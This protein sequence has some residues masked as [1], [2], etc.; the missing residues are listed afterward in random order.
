MKGKAVSSQVQLILAAQQPFV[1][2]LL[3]SG[4]LHLAEDPQ[5][6]DFLAGNPQEIA[7]RR[8][9]GTLKRWIEPKDK[10]WF[11]YKMMHPAAQ[12]AAAAGLS[13]ELGMQFQPEDIL[14]ARGAHGALWQSLKIVLEAEDEVIY[15]SPPWFFYEAIILGAGGR[16]VRVKVRDD[17]FDLDL[18]AIRN[19]ITEKTRV[20][21]IN[22][23]NNPTGRIYP[24]DTLE[25]LGQLLA[26]ASQRN[27]RPIYLLSD[28]AYSRIV[29]DG[30]LFHTPGRYYPYSLLVHTY[31]KSA[32]APGQRLG[33]VALPPSLPD[34][35]QVRLAFL[36]VMFATGGG[37][38]DAVMQYA[39]PEIDKMSIDLKLLQSKR[40]EMGRALRD[41]GY[42]FHFPE[43]TFYLLVKSPV[44]DDAGFAARLARDKVLVLPGRAFEMP[45]YFRISLTATR[46]MIQRSLPVFAAAIAESG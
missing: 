44:P 26:D 1:D 30:R 24:P 42:E 3:G 43:A 21:L 19:A 37:L 12:E 40:D 17:D 15:M 45:G 7:S 11:A 8:Y 28:E 6:C 38:P 27:G 5:A 29:F 14:L 39:L 16:P 13:E 18:E 35:E 41:L 34:R 10:N 23:P 31:S 22:T 25:P 2:A 20:V 32:L 36:A 4:L 46:E 33:F 9:V